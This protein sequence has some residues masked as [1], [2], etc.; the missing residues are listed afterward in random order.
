MIYSD[1]SNKE[2]LESKVNL[3]ASKYLM[4][5]TKTF[6]TKETTAPIVNPTRED[7]NR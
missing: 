2:G 6:A 7:V 4:P 3:R 5:L 1:K